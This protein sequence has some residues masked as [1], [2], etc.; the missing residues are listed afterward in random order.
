MVLVY[1]S[2]ALSVGNR[3]GSLFG[4]DSDSSPD[5]D[6]AWSRSLRK[7]HSIVAVPG[8]PGRGENPLRPLPERATVLDISSDT[9]PTPAAWVFTPGAGTAGGQVKLEQRNRLRVFAGQP[10]ATDPSR[11]TIAYDVDGTPGILRGRLK[12]DDTIEL[13]PSTGKLVGDRWHP[14]TQPATLPAEGKVGA[15]MSVSSCRHAQALFRR[16]RP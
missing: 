4:G 8:V 16:S 5:P 15:S 12:D 14:A 7:S 2:G 6:K 10:D 9:T 13:R 11:F 3:S 1:V